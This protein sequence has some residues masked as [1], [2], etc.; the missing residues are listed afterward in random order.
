L[1]IELYS[2][3]SYDVQ[4]YVCPDYSGGL[5]IGFKQLN[6]MSTLIDCRSGLVHYG[7]SDDDAEDMVRGRTAVPLFHADTYAVSFT[8]QNAGGEKDPHA[9]ARGAKVHLVIPKPY[10]HPALDNY[11]KDFQPEYRGHAGKVRKVVRRWE[12]ATV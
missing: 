12:K 10:Q 11:Y 3:K 1:T 8:M 2:G 7:I 4:F 5:L 6:K 9:I